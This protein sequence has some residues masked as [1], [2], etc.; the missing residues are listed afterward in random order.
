MK[1]LRGSGSIPAER[2][3]PE[4]RQRF[5]CLQLGMQ[6]SAGLRGTHLRGRLPTARVPLWLLPALCRCCA[7]CSAVLPAAGGD[8]CSF[9]SDL[10]NS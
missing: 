1:A 10:Q 7:G 6:I 2:S 9:P 4:R 3:P 8:D 5:P